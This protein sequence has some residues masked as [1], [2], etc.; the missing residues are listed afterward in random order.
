MQSV[1]NHGLHLLRRT[2]SL[3]E[4]GSSPALGDTDQ[5]TEEQEE[6]EGHYDAGYEGDLLDEDVVCLGIRDLG[7]DDQFKHECFGEVSPEF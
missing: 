5:H 6:G 7:Q 3:K 4:F 1:T 2:V